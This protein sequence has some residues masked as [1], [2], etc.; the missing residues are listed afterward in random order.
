VAHLI[1]V[2]DEAPVELIRLLRCLEARRGQPT[3]EPSAPKDRQ[4]LHSFSALLS[5]FL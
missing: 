4:H 2:Y 5:F 3:T 1:R